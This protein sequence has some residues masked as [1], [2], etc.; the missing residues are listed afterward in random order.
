MHFVFCCEYYHPSRGGVQEVMRQIAERLVGRGHRVT[1]ATTALK[2]R[3][4]S[5]YNGVEIVEFRASG[6]HVSGLRGEIEKFQHFLT[7]VQCDAVMVKAA[8]QWTFDAMWPI[9]DRI[10]A[11]KVFIPCGFSSLY[12]PAFARYFADMP[13]VL[14]KFDHLIFYAERYRDIDF[15][16]EHGISRFSIVPNGASDVEFAVAPDPS[17]RSR[18]G[19]GGSDF[20]FLVV[21]SPVIAKGHREVAEAFARLDTGGRAATLVLNGAWPKRDYLQYVRFPFVAARRVAQIAQREGG[22]AVLRRS[23]AFLGRRGIL[24]APPVEDDA[25][26]AGAAAQVAPG[27]SAELPPEPQDVARSMLAIRDDPFKRIVCT[28]LT[29]DDVVQA[30]MAADLFVYASNVDYS[31]LVLFEAAAAGTPF[32]TVPVGNAE[33]IVAWTKAGVICPAARDRFGYTRTSPAVLAAEMRR[34]MV[35]PDLLEQLGAAGLENWRKAYNWGA[36]ALR[37][38]AVLLGREIA[39]GNTIE[40][41]A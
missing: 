28:T 30:F 40:S 10:K 16:R 3:K 36:I 24:F 7:T 26:A 2:E 12:E 17:W 11:R 41:K 1:I 34:C 15:A 23:K 20:M 6:N 35:A 14:R 5:S 33:E 31:P 27:A 19:I 38:E 8:Q 9:L 32:L 21:G 22:A 39:V 18:H 25:S 29:R 4:F 37:Y 13:E